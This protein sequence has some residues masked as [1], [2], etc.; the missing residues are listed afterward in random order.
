MLDFATNAARSVLGIVGV[1]EQRV[2]G[3]TGDVGDLREAVTA[4]HRTADA[5]ER[6]PPAAEPRIQRRV[7]DQAVDRAEDGRP[8]PASGHVPVPV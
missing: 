6:H 5:V 8:Q 1:A 7:R 4:M 3:L 2:E